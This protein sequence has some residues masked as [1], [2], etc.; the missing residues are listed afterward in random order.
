MPILPRGGRDRGGSGVLSGPTSSSNKGRRSK[1]VV[2]PGPTALG[3]ER[4]VEC[5]EGPAHGGHTACLG[6]VGDV[7]PLICARGFSPDGGGILPLRGQTQVVGT[8]KHP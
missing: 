5:A 1:G 6:A 7:V 8:D 3:W 2:C 4:P